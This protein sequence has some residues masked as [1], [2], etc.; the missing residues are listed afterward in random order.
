MNNGSAY[1]QCNGNVCPS[2]QRE[3][4]MPIMC[5]CIKGQLYAKAIVDRA[6]PIQ[7]RAS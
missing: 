4:F 3:N 2:A 7:V 1:Q 5:L 6:Y